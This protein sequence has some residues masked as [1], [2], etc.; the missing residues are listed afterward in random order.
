MK[1]NKILLIK[2]P[3]RYLENEFVYQ[4]LGPH[5]L[6]SFLMQYE[7]PSD[8]LV[9]YED[10]TSREN[11]RNGS[12]ESP[13]TRDLNMLMIDSNGRSFDQPFDHEILGSYAIIGMSVMSP[14]APDAYLI[15]ELINRI[16]PS[17][18]TVIGGSHPRYY[19]DQVT[20]LSPTFAFDFVVPQDGW[21]PMLQNT[22]PNKVRTYPYH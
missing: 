14:Q 8:I 19:L 10:V 9:L 1:D 20:S 18:T 17:I 13:S 22:L 21:A 6:Q 5:Y 11:R 4:Q 16:Y 12:T 15:I 2:P 3:D 7:I